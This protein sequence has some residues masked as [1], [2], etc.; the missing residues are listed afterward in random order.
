MKKY[1]VKRTTKHL[2][3]IHILSAD[4]K[5]PLCH[6]SNGVMAGNDWKVEE[7]E[8]ISFMELCWHCS[9]EAKCIA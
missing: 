3:R 8:N 5:H 9:K 2:T 7:R 1:L 6:R 4:G